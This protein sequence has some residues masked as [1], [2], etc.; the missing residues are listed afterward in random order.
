MSD[1]KMIRIS[2]AAKKLN[3]GIATIAEFLN[4][5]GFEVDSKPNTKITHYQYTL[6][7]REYAGSIAVKKEAEKLTIGKRIEKPELASEVVSEQIPPVEQT[8]PIQIESEPNLPAEKPE[9]EPPAPIQ[10]SAVETREVPAQPVDKIEEVPKQGKSQVDKKDEIIIEK[11]QLTGLKIVGKINLE[12]NKPK[13]AKTNKNKVKSIKTPNPTGIKKTAKPKR[14]TTQ[15][16]SKHEEETAQKPSDKS[17]SIEVPTPVKKEIP[18][19]TPAELIEAKADKLQGLRVLGKIELAE[20]KTVKPVASSDEKKQKKRKRKRVKSP[21]TDAN[22]AM[23][24]QETTPKRSQRGGKKR[25]P[26]KTKNKKVEVSEKEV[27]EE[28]KKTLARMSVGTDS[29][30]T[31]KRQHR[32]EKRFASQVAKE[33]EILEAQ[34]DATKLKVTEFISTL[35][36]STLMGVSVNEIISKAMALGIFIS[37]NHRLEA[38]IITLIAEYFGYLV[39]FTSVEEDIDSLE[40]EDEDN[41]ELLPRAPIVTIMGHV[42]HGKT[43]LLDYIRDSRIVQGEAGG[44][45]QHIGAYDVITKSKRRIA[46]LDTPGHEAFTAMRARGAKLTDVVII[47]I[48]ADDS[49]MPQTIEALNHASVANVPIVIAINK[50]DKPTAN[51]NKI[52][53][54]LANLNYLVEGWGGKY[55]CYEISAKTGQGVEGLLEGVLL[56]ADILE[57]KANPNKKAVGTVVEASLDRGRGYVATILVQSGTLCV[58]DIILAGPHHGRVKAMTDH[59]SKPLK[60]V[61]PAT[62]VQVLGLGG[63]PQAGDKFNVMNTEREAREIAIKREQIIRE[64]TIRATKRTTLSDIGRRIAIGSFQQLNIII[65]GDVDG[66]VEALSDSLL[67]LS[68][69]EVEINIIHKA[70]GPIS[71]SDILLA[72][73]SEA[74]VIGFQVRPTPSARKIADKE[75]IEIRLYSVIFEATNDVKDAM[76]GML[77]PEIEEIIVG[78]IEVRE[79]F[80]ITKVGT[81]GGCYVMDGYVKRT[82]K[83]RIIRDGIVTYGGEEGGEINALK[84]FKEDVNEVKHNFECGLSIKNFNDIKVGDIIE[85]FE[86]KEVKR[87]LT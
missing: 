86:Q 70:V 47:V 18:E 80:K 53:E 37:I 15:K 14:K 32:K 63:A 79:V 10:S 6:L 28:M 16:L 73:A 59:R 83:I 52:K 48:A 82:S 42:D 77:A 23:P 76:E 30:L 64:Q 46:F 19:K 12:A 5:K 34:K 39:E 27:Q 69:Q 78:N 74:I 8:P 87:A 7:Q 41:G 20:E 66:S 11:K 75:N 40:V 36:L 72:T 31:S 33:Q 43:S 65:R 67:K 13:A 38:D 71:E 56:E 25:K 3:V 61:P 85:V 54:E 81:V 62:P 24:A 2:Q 29:K 55:Q 50:V 9:P 1:Q 21:L 45:T 60:N 35:E 84:R 26:K 57:L 49:V 22:A 4:K 17:T 58:G 51:A 68:T 44:I